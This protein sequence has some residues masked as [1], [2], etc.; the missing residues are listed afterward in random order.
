MNF[1]QVFD[2]LNLGLVILDKDLHI[3]YWNNWMATHSGLVKENLIGRNLLD[4]FPNL[5][6]PI[7]AR[8]IKSVLTFGNYYFFSQKLHGYLFPMK[9]SGTFKGEFQMMQQSCTAYPIRED[10]KRISHICITVQDV[11]E[12]ARYEKALIEMNLRDGLTGAYNR[13]FLTMRLAEEFERHRRYSRSLS[14]L[15]LDLDYFKKINDAYGHQC[16][17]YILK[18]VCDT[19]SSIL[20]KVDLLIR[21][22]GEEFCCLLPETDLNAALKLA[23]RI[24]QSIAEKDFLYNDDKIHITVSIGVHEFRGDIDSSDTLLRKADEGL[25]KA[26]KAG[27]NKVFSV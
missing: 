22:G 7:F 23:E 27:R 8:S 14:L 10:N 12:I 1:T 19:I 2:M 4:A 6:N 3:Q 26:K 18:D 11:T 5:D 15:M 16:G 20:R 21:Y 9:T 25:Y 17:D 24:R 13:R